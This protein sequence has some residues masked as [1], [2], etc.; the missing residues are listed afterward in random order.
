MDPSL[1][2]T[3]A[4]RSNAGFYENG[5]LTR[6]PDQIASISFGSQS[7]CEPEPPGD[8]LD[9][10]HKERLVRAAELE[11]ARRKKRARHLPA[12]LFG[13]AA[14]S[15]LLDLYVSEHYGRTVSTTSACLAAEVPPTTALRWLE[16]LEAK[17]LV[18]RVPMKGDRRVRH[19]VLTGEA[20]STISNLLAHYV[21]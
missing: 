5:S 9:Q 13:E 6:S 11:L 21:S 7:G 1:T 2:K 10:R 16:L 15:M 12:E 14:W 19:V 18:R 8:A 20:Y 3:A 4:I 17:Q